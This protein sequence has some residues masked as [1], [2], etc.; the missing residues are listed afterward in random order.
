VATSVCLPGTAARE[1][2]VC[3]RA[4]RFGRLKADLIEEACSESDLFA[5]SLAF[6]EQEARLASTPH[7]RKLYYSVKNQMKGHVMKSCMDYAFPE[8]CFPEAVER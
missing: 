7:R 4:M 3:C 6:A 5:R 8:Q 2:T 1:L